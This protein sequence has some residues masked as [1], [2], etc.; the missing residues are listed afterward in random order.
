MNVIEERMH[1]RPAKGRTDR[2]H[3]E[4]SP[5]GRALHR[6]LGDRERV[7]YVVRGGRWGLVLAPL[8]PAV[9]ISVATAVD[10]PT[11]VNPNLEFRPDAVFASL[12][13]LVTTPAFVYLSRHV[14]V[15]GSY[16][17]CPKC[18]RK[19][20]TLRAGIE[21]RLTCDGCGNALTDLM[22]NDVVPSVR[23]PWSSL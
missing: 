8:L 20:E 15:P 13:L 5:G 1:G 6:W 9:F 21:G 7:T 22:E 19:Q 23:R 3:W 14:P 12:A 11:V 17:N 2:T 10:S 4:Q 16:P 18:L